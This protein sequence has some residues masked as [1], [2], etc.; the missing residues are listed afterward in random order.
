MK[1]ENQEFTITSREET[2]RV[3]KI[4]P[5]ELLSISTQVDFDK[6]E[7]TANLAKFSLEHAE[8]LQGNK[9]LP[10]KTKDKEVYWP[11]GIE[12]DPIALQEIF[13]YIT[14]EVVIKSF[15]KSSE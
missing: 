9:W 13:D 5:V 8:V 1:F 4:T 10:V 2:F 7:Q 11:N 3:G 12:D 6:L 15:M 14:Y